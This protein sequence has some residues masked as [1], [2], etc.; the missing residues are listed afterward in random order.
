VT[1][2][3]RIPARDHAKLEEVSKKTFRGKSDVIRLGLALVFQREL[4]KEIQKGEGDEA[5]D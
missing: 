1:L 2:S 3:V 4:K 5:G